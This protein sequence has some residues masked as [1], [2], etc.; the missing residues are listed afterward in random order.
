[1]L[2]VSI[3]DSILNSVVA[4]EGKV[5][6]RQDYSMPMGKA[7]WYALL[8]LVPI[9]VGLSALYVAIWDY[10]KPVNEFIALMGK[11]ARLLMADVLLIGILIVGTAAHEFIHA[12]T[13]WLVGR[14]PWSA[15]KFGF[16]WRTL[17]PYMHLQEP[18]PVKVYRIGTW[19]PGFWTGIVPA[20]YGLVS[21]NVWI[22]LLGG[23]FTCAAGGDALVLWSLRDVDK[24][25]LVEDH[26]T[27]AGCYILRELMNDRVD[28]ER[29]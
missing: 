21:G 22:T 19:M 25:A 29:A 27:Q 10:Q 24:T 18:L 7:N 13:W 2:L 5:Y 16:Q 9:M 14:K 17:T 4:A 15:I 8:I 23:I 20:A 11:P 28:N 3:G 6:D 26:P 1:M 12:L